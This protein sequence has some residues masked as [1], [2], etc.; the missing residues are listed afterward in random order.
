MLRA[1]CVFGKLEQHQAALFRRA[2]LP[3]CSH[4]NI[5]YGTLFKNLQVQYV[6]TALMVMK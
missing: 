5:F 2:T 3:A 4:V 6:I 1:Q